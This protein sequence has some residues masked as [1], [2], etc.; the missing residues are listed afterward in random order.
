MP[1]SFHNRVFLS[2]CFAVRH[3]ARS[4]SLLFLLARP[5]ARVIPGVLLATVVGCG[6]LGSNFKEVTGSITL[7]GE[8]LEEAKVEFYPKAEGASSAFAYIDARG[9]FELVFAGTKKGTQPGLY[10]VSISKVEDAPEGERETLPPIY[11]VRTKL[12]ADVSADGE[13]D[14]TFELKTKP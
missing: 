11:N 9:R 14:F 1:A 3:G 6:S 5:S 7:D 8:P 2:C 10:A 12:S 13:N 4:G